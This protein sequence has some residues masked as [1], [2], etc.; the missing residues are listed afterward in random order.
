MVITRVI[1]DPVNF[2][3]LPTIWRLSFQ[4][5]NIHHLLSALSS[6]SNHHHHCRCRRCC[7]RRPEC[8]RLCHR[9]S[10]SL[11]K[12]HPGSGQ[13]WVVLI[14]PLGRPSISLRPFRRLLYPHGRYL[15][16]SWKASLSPVEGISLTRSPYH[17]QRYHIPEP[18]LWPKVAVSGQKLPEKKNLTLFIQSMQRY[19]A[20]RRTW[21]AV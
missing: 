10:L 6:G 11:S 9:R 3:I 21:A 15:R 20:M 14:S 17:L 13:L 16:G 4:F 12:S 19:S 7:R 1:N 5:L 8:R 2:R 18:V